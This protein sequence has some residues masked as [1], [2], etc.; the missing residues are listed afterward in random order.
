MKMD[1]I[2]SGQER[3]CQWYPV[4]TQQDQ[5]LVWH[6]SL[7]V[8]SDGK[9]MT[10]SEELSVVFKTRFSEMASSTYPLHFDEER[11]VK[12]L[13]RLQTETFSEQSQDD[14]AFTLADLRQQLA[15]SRCRTC[16]LR[17]TL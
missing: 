8:P 17:T 14:E 5:Y 11:L 6:W 12:L 2:G 1:L 7:V 16:G 10:S 15:R 13:L 3:R 9:P 4:R